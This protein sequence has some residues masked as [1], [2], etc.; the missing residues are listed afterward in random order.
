MYGGPGS[1]TPSNELTPERTGRPH[2]PGSGQ[3]RPSRSPLPTYRGADEIFPDFD[4]NDRLPD[5]LRPSASLAKLDL[6]IAP[7]E[8]RSAISP[9]TPRARVPFDE[10]GTSNTRRRESFPPLSEHRQYPSAPGPGMSTSQSASQGFSRVP[11]NSLAD[12]MANLSLRSSSSYGP[13]SSRPLPQATAGS[14]PAFY[15]PPSYPTYSSTSSSSTYLTQPTGASSMYPPRTTPSPSPTPVSSGFVSPG[16]ADYQYTATYGRGSVSPGNT[17]SSSYLTQPSQPAHSQVH[18]TSDPGFYQPPQAT[19]PVPTTSMY[20]Q[21]A[22]SSLPQDNSFSSHYSS[23]YHQQSP[24]PP[25]QQQSL[26]SSPPHASSISS[27]P[28]AQGIH[29]H[30]DFMPQPQPAP[31]QPQ[32]NN[33]S[34]PPPQSNSAPYQPSTTPQPQTH[35]TNSQFGTS[36]SIPWNPQPLESRAPLPSHSA[37][38]PSQYDHGVTGVTYTNSTLPS[39]GGGHG[40]G[41][42]MSSSGS[43]TGRPLPDPQQGGHGYAHSQPIMS[44]SGYGYAPMPAPASVPAPATVPMQP[45]QSQPPLQPQIPLNSSLNAPPPIPVVNTMTGPPPSLQTQL[46]SPSQ[47]PISAYEQ[48]QQ[49]Q[50]QQQQNLLPPPQNEQAYGNGG[51][52]QRSQSLPPVGPVG[53]QVY[54]DPQQQQPIYEQPQYQ[55]QPVYEPPPP[56]QLPQ[57]GYLNYSSNKYSSVPPPPPL[58]SHGLTGSIVPPPPP[59]PIPTTPPYQYQQSQQQQSYSPQPMGSNVPFSP[60]PPPPPLVGTYQNHS[61][62]GW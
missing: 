6:Y 61:S 27:L 59:P 39:P 4:R 42:R 46:P 16:Q 17:G 33:N 35:Y 32:Y 56:P 24:Q 36:P 55:H 14:R 21:P 50:Q 19:T 25:Q 18:R 7:Y 20:S 10:F 34:L 28:S 2:Q 31:Y 22:P 51:A 41:P 53:N 12:D 62:A 44:T 5:T 54:P 47:Q 52:Q 3:R 23:P 1:F 37:P 43:G 40:H 60:P 8:N 57:Q 13:S 30:Y 49:M 9:T 45:M 15:E 48:F 38:P 58:P 11:S 29:S 26:Y